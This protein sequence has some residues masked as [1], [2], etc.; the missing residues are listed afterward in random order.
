MK[1]INLHKEAAIY[2]KERG[3]FLSKEEDNWTVSP[4]N[5]VKVELKD[6]GKKEANIILG[7]G[8]NSDNDLKNLKVLISP[9][10]ELNNNKY[11]TFCL[12]STIED[13]K[14]VVELIESMS[15]TIESPYS[16]PV[17][18]KDNMEKGNEEI[19][20]YL[21]SNDIEFNEISWGIE[22][23]VS[24]VKLEWNARDK[25]QVVIGYGNSDK[26][27]ENLINLFKTRFYIGN[28]KK[29]VRI[30]GT[31]SNFKE[32]V[33]ILSDLP[34]EIEKSASI[35]RGDIKLNKENFYLKTAKLIRWSVENEYPVLGRDSLHFDG[36]DEFITIGESINGRE[37]REHVV[38]C[39][40]LIREGIEM[41]RAGKSDTEIALM[42]K[43]NLIIV[44]IT[45]EE[46]A[47][48]DGELGLKITMP[49]GWKLGDDP[50]ER[51]YAAGI[52]LK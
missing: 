3:H 10:Y 32:A 30:Y 31:V 40:Y 23:Y 48:L 49:D 4:I 33:T 24:G 6:K 5:G 45:N 1:N 26:D 21:E 35:K 18:G 9:Y 29:S 25:K 12:D 2:L 41:I 27:I 17:S 36:L 42:L 11:L 16:P 39:D 50:L 8:G 28:N 22:A 47:K 38:P 13:F 46:A 14:K 15:F 20:Q 52:K 43:Q 37:Y 19:I 44:L 51:L 7:Y 34:F